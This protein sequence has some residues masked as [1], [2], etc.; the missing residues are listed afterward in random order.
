MTV[1]I[2]P[3]GNT[4][5]QRVGVASNAH[6]GRDFEDAVHR[7]FAARGVDLGRDFSV[8]IGHD[9]K[10]AHRFDLGSDDPPI[11]MECKSYTWTS[12]GNSPSAKLRSLNEAMLM[13]SVAPRH[14]RKLLV[15]LK[16]MRGETSLAFHYART[17]GHL[18][19]PDVE[20]WEFDPDCNTVEL[21]WPRRRSGNHSDQIVG[22]PAPDRV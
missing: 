21:I 9:L 3:P 17:Q 13:F 2:N 16:H 8:E 7:F 14:F 22:S 10:K 15:M 12:G 6:A 20:I 18:V 5:H 19:G 11:L 1:P 4:N